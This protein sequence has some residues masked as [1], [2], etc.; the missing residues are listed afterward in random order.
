MSQ[1]QNNFSV[2]KLYQTVIDD[3]MAGVREAFLDE[4]VDE[5]VL[6]ELKM[7]WEA[8]LLA[9]R[10]VE[11]S[12]PSAATENSNTSGTDG[13]N[14]QQ[15]SHPQQTRPNANSNNSSSQQQQ[16]PQQQQQQQQQ[17]QP[18]P[19]ATILPN[20][21]NEMIPIQITLPNDPS[22]VQRSIQIQVP[23][24]CIHT[25]KLQEILTLPTIQATLSL[26][27][28]LAAVHLQQQVMAALN[29]GPNR[30]Q[31][32]S[33]ITQISRPASVITSQSQHQNQQRPLNPMVH[34][35]GG[36]VGDS[37]DEEEEEE[38]DDDDF[39]DDVDDKDDERED[40]QEDEGQDEEPLNS[41]DDVSDNEESNDKLYEIDNVV[42]CQYD[43]ITRSRNKWK[44]HLKDGIMNLN[45]KDYVFQKANGDAEW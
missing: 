14:Q 4:G 33:V 2:K 44:F 20:D 8:K 29:I 19:Q 37:S 42:V 27:S 28:D 5:Q 21:P 18:P 13:G 45:G 9:T 22:G 31:G 32:N 35:D 41:G 15:Q 17:S 24:S 25:N 30:G 3:V 43:K 23:A 10:A 6:Q 34:L 40:E 36:A 11:P 12:P 26:P 1:G 38:E 39:D 7:L 16:Q